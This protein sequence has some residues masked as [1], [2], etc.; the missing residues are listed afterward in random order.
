MHLVFDSWSN[1]SNIQINFHE[2][3]FKCEIGVKAHD[4]LFAATGSVMDEAF[5]LC[6]LKFIFSQYFANL[7]IIFKITNF[8]INNIIKTK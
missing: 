7:I 8:E 1:D 3:Q 6:L 2:W 5:N 4:A